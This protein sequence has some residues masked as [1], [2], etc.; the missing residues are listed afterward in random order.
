[1]ADGYL[2]FDTSIDT[3]GFNK[4]TK[5]I[6]SCLGGLKSALGKVA[7][8]AAAAFSVKQIIVFGKQAVET[9]SDMAEV[10]N[11]V[12]TAF[13]DMSYKMEDFAKTSIKQFG[14]S[15]LAAKQ[16]GSTFMAMAAGMGLAQDS[17][18]DMAVSLTGL[19]ADMASFYNVSQDVASTALKSIFTGE[20]ETLKQFGIVM[21][22]ANLQAYALSQG[23]TKAT[24][25]M[26][27]AEKVQL[28]YS[29]VM[30]QTSLAQGDFAKTQDSWANQTRILSEQWKEFGA[31]IGSVLM[32]ALLPAVKTLNSALSNLISYAK[33]TAQAIAD[34]FGIE[35]QTGS[36]ASSLADNAASAAESYTDMADNAEK[37]AEAQENSLASFDKVN[38]LSDSSADSSSA[39]TSAGSG[40][41]NQGNIFTSVDVKTSAAEKKLKSFF[42]WVKSSFKT[43]FQPFKSAWDKNGASVIDSAKKAWEGLKGVASSVGSSFADVWSNGTGEQYISNILRGWQDILGI[44]GDVSNALKKAW[45][46]DGSGTALIQSYFD[47]C[48]SWQDLI[49]TISD[50]LRNVWNNGTGEEVFTNII[51][52][53]TNIND[54]VTNLQDKFKAAWSEN[55]TGKGIIQDIFDILNDVLGTINDITADTKEW[56]AE[57]D[58]TPLLTSIEDLLDAIEP[59]TDNIGDGLEWFWNNVLLP[60]AGWT[61]EEVIPDFLDLLSAAIDVLTSAVEALKPLGEW[62]WDKFLEPIAS[63]TGGVITDVLEGIT[64]ALKGVSD[65]ISAHQTAVEN[66]AIVIGTLGASF[67]IAGVINA[68]VTALSSASVVMGL[69]TP[70]TTALGAAI[71]FLTSPITLVVLAI[72]ALIAI[73]VLL[74][75]NWDEIK[76]FASEIWASIQETLFA[77]F[78]WCGEKFNELVEFLS[79]IWESIKEVFSAVGDWFTEI[80]TEAWEGIKSA[81]SSVKKWFSDLWESIKNVFKAVGDWFSKK[82]TQA[83]DNIKTAW[84]NVKGWFSDLWT[85][86]KEVFSAV[87]SWFSEKFTAAWDNIKSAFSSTAKFFSDLWTAIK[88]PFVKVADWFKEV[89]SKAWEKVKGVFSTGGKIFD[90]IKDGIS[91][92]FTS[93]VNKLI[94]GINVI[95]AKPLEFL[96]GVLNDIR[97]IE[98]AGFTP[99]DE[100]WGYDPIPV[101]QIPKLATGTVVP[102]NYGEF[103]A[104]LGDNKKETEIVSPLSTIEQAVANALARYGGI[105]GDITLEIPII[106]D[107][108]KLHR[109]IVKVNKAQIRK[110]GKNPLAT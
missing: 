60:M 84:N 32:N 62:L 26:S 93:V 46:D 43:L 25:E 105:G 40:I 41:A 69:L 44:I 8:A 54:T 4:G 13:G 35:L 21:T 59:L 94:D 31:T 14:I 85:G 87:G 29:Y 9:A 28:R 19:S 55:D 98:I 66:L 90:G 64:T 63:W 106:L 70:I 3:Q 86:I 107:G 99:F 10:Q 110:T 79:G 88:K 103:L 72:G 24:S 7:I 57:L 89:F 74:Y 75:K 81:W 47:N 77:F 61:I 36:D 49:H 53:L 67:A 100:L 78:D 97:D 27:Q 56:A 102:A 11:V 73:G 104:V 92:V 52:S 23:I 6:T 15:Q 108:I 42:K 17:A 45:N 76:E 95:I 101:P 91:G 48:L 2:N 82:F 80:F 12:D 1:M 22:D 58:F 38:K 65:W 51:Q 37:A 20:T 50:D 71:N 96:N 34:A 30:H 33:S 68:V 83:W 109:A 5:N 18:S 16:T 39:A